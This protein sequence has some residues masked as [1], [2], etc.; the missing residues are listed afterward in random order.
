METFDLIIDRRVEGWRR[1]KIS[2]EAESLEGA[3]KKALDYDYISEDSEFL[4]ETEEIH[5]S[6]MVEIMDTSGKLLKGY[7]GD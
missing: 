5:P 4:Y 3:L 2:I 7:Y 6:G 1:D